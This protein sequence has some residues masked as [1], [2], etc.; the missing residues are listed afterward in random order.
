MN[1]EQVKQLI[2]NVGMMT[3]LWVITFNG[4]VNQGLPEAVALN[5]TKAFM[6]AMFEAFV[7]PNGSGKE[8]E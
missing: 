8:E 2:Q 1:N 5:H 7:T 6:S 4:F 3:E